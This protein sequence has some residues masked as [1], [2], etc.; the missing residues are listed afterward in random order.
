VEEGVKSRLLEFV[1]RLRA[2]GLPISPSETLDASRALGVFGIEPVQF[3]EALAATVVKDEGDRATFDAEFAQFFAV[4][5]RHGGKRGRSQASGLGG[6]A[7]ASQPADPSGRAHAEHPERRTAKAEEQKQH[8][9]Q[10]QHGDRQRLG[11]LR[12]LQDIPL[13][14]LTPEQVEECDLLLRRLADQLRAHRQRR[15]RQARHG[16]LDLRRTLRT[17]LG[18][19]GVPMVPEFRTRR[20]GKP[21]LVVLCDLSHSVTLASRF[22]LSLLGGAA[23]LFRR[24]CLFGYVALP[25]EIWLQDG[26]VVMDEPLDLFARSDFGRVLER[27]WEARYR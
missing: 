4:P 2:A 26:Q 21:D 5:L 25:V 9:P 24:V 14:A 11:R 19:G 12:S 7:S 17:S 15:V 6:A 22:L 20:P 18:S 3:R 8:D 1:D 10:K 13:K 16:R 27:F 23:S